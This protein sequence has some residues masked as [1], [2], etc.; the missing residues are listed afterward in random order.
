MKRNEETKVETMYNKTESITRQ[1]P[2]I[3][4]ENAEELTEIGGKKDF[5]ST[6]N[7]ADCIKD[8]ISGCY[9]MQLYATI[10]AN[11]LM[12]QKKVKPLIKKL[13]KTEKKAC[14]DFATKLREKE[15]EEW[16]T[17]SD[18]DDSK[19]KRNKDGISVPSHY[20]KYTIEDRRS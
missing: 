9:L 5:L 7:A 12:R 20:K 19:E 17:D 14:E 8:I 10:A 18:S 16:V 4:W 13:T 3:E 11:A 15:L 6:V 1:F 2:V